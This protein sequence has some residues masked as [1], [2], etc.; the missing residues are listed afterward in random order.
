VFLFAL[1][2]VKWPTKTPV[3]HPATCVCVRDL[4]I[5]EP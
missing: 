1:G 5:Q 3:E 4:D 2:D